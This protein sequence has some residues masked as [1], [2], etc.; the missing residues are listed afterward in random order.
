MKKVKVEVMLS[1]CLIMHRILKFR[2]SLG[3]PPQFAHWPL[4]G[5]ELSASCFVLL[6]EKGPAMSIWQETE[7]AAF[8][9]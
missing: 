6:M 1:L 8:G 3:K 5:A 9:M 4:H 2:V 7:V